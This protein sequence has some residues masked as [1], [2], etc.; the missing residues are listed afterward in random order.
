MRAEVHV[1][2]IVYGILESLVVQKVRFTI[3]ILKK[4]CSKKDQ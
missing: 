4:S 3:T 1:I 2:T